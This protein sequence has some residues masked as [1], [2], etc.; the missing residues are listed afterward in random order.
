MAAPL[1]YV[2]QANFPLGIR[3]MGTP[4]LG[5]TTGKIFFVDSTAINTKGDD[6]NHGN[7]PQ[8][9][10]ATIDFAIGQCQ[11]DRGDII[12]VLT[13]HEETLTAAG[14]INLDVAGVTIEGLGEGD[15]R[16]RLTFA[17]STAAS[18]TLN[19][20]SCRLVNL[21]FDMTGIDALGPGST[22]GV[23]VL[24]ADGVVKNCRF[25]IATTGNQVLNALLL[26]AASVRAKVLYNEF[27][28]PITAGPGSAILMTGAGVTTV[29]GI[30]IGWNRIVGN[31]TSAA[32]V[33]NM[34][35]TIINAFIHDNIITAGGT[36]QDCLSITVGLGSSG[37]VA[38]N[39]FLGTD[40]TTVYSVLA[41]GL[42][43]IENYAYD[44][45]TTGLL[46]VPVP[47]VGSQLPANT[48]LIDQI[49]GQEFSWK[50]S[51]Y[52]KVTA[53]FSSATW[54]TVATH[55]ILVVTGPYRLI[56]IPE[57][58]L[59]LTS[60][61]AATISLGDDISSSALIAATTATDIDVLEYWLSTT[62]ARR[63]NKSS[64]IDIIV[65]GQDIGYEIA[66]AAL[67]GGQIDFHIW[68]MPLSDDAV[69]IAAGAGGVL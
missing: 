42:A 44:I 32:I 19:A 12:K 4:L 43:N 5:E 56:I 50:Q 69:S 53:D 7:T 37:I 14:A 18:I 13:G 26:T 25:I 8:S 67:T 64:V 63:Y 59:D 27:D 15:S 6:T 48:N 3:S 33:F 58:L 22:G 31:F 11:A 46:A 17:S 36:A 1:Q 38:N 47:I 41:E 9:P 35:D 30:E 24:A 55:E 57:C 62:P 20:A 29:E 45:N 60:G 51:N 10:F 39:K 40:V 52:L 2:D 66:T 61:G 23:Q 49:L 65:N 68:Y 54:N 16:P 21:I 28:G 34:T